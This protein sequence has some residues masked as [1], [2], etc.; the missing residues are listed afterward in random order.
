MRAHTRVYLFAYVDILTVNL[1]DRGSVMMER[2]EIDFFHHLVLG[3]RV[4]EARVA[5][6]TYYVFL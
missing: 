3:E 5:P 2:L 1:V 4:T 6:F